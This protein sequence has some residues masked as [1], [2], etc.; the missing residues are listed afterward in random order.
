MAQQNGTVDVQR[1][2]NGCTVIYIKGKKNTNRRLKKKKCSYCSYSVAWYCS[3]CSKKKKKVANQNGIVDKQ[4]KT[5]YEQ[6]K[7]TIEKKAQIDDW[8]KKKNDE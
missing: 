4:W 7:N 6:C 8:E 2:N 3:Y 1:K 5:L